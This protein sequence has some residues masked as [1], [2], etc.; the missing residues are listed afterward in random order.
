M[1]AFSKRPF[2][3]FLSF[4]LL[5]T[6][7]FSLFYFWIIDF[8]K[9]D[10]IVGKFVMT[11]GMMGLV[12]SSFLYFKRF[13]P[14]LI[15]YLLQVIF[16]FMHIT[17]YAY[18]QSPLNIINE[19]RLLSEAV[20]L[21]KNF[22]VPIPSFIAII[23]L[24]FPLFL[25]V[26][27][28]Y[29]SISMSSASPLKMGTPRTWSCFLFAFLFTFQQIIFYF[30]E[31]L[32]IKKIMGSYYGFRDSYFIICYGLI[33]HNLTRY[34]L[35]SSEPEVIKKIKYGE[36]IQSRGSTKPFA[37]FILIQ[38]ESLQ[39]GIQEVKHNN[40]YV[41]PYLNRLSRESFFY[42]YCLAYHSK[43]G[44]SDAEISILNNIEPSHE[45]PLINLMTYDYPN[46]LFKKL[47]FHRYQN[48][49]FHSNDG[50]F[51]F[52]EVAYKKMRGVEFFDGGAIG[53][54]Q[55]WRWG[56]PD[57]ILFNFV[58]EQVKTER[59]PFFHY[60]ITMTSH[61]P[62]NYVNRYSTN[63]DY[64]DIRD[65]LTRN[66][67]K[68]MAYVDRELEKFIDSIVKNKKNTY[69]FIYGDHSAIDSEFLPKS[70]LKIDG[71]Y[72]EF[73]PLFIITPNKKKYRET[74]QVAFFPD[75]GVTVLYQAGIPF[76]YLAWGENLLDTGEK[77]KAIFFKG[78]Q[79]KKDYL[80]EMIDAKLEA[81]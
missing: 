41:T 37:S 67:F 52:R 30:D 54:P 14:F 74:K 35:Y 51:Y 39:S 58:S 48:K 10:W 17:Y 11:L 61:E 16:L 44:S 78:K 15:L 7:K 34:A 9:P 38:V 21:V 63:S 53:M 47:K 45:I 22:A 20:V 69:I 57:E 31:P 79:Y 77:K 76:D 32:S 42:P 19:I 28:S 65:T 70:A 33:A 36:A 18:F 12:Y 25:W 43:G 5:N 2:I 29:R 73:V 71:D 4:I 27:L 75:I 26:S 64:D 81:K 60:I 50:R 8:K 72:L 59:G 55:K 24:D 6:L 49:V 66:Y 1:L 46:S 13:W 56:G 3:I 23:F 62:F 80:Y 40:R 68:T